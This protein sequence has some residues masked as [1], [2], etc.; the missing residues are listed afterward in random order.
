MRAVMVR[1]WPIL[2][3]CATAAMAACGGPNRPSPNVKEKVTTAEQPPPS[4]ITRSRE[5]A[6][7]FKPTS[8]PGDAPTIYVRDERSSRL[9]VKLPKGGKAKEEWTQPLGGTAKRL[10]CRGLCTPMQASFVLAAG[11]RVAVAGAEEWVTFDTN[12]R[13]V[14]RGKIEAPSGQ[15]RLDRAA[16]TIV[17]DETRAADLP[18][19]AKVAARNGL[20]VLV[21][22]GGVF[23]GEKAIEGKFDAFD[24]AIDEAGYACVLVRQADDLLMWTV[25]VDNK[26]SIGRQKLPG[27]AANARKRV[28]G[29]PVLGKNLR[30]V[31][32][33]THALAL[34]LEGKKI[35]ERKGVPTGGMSITA[36]DHVLIADNG[37]VLAIDPKGKTTELWSSKDAIF[38]TPPILNAS[39]MLFVASGESLH[40]VS[41]RE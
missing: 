12:G 5:E 8:G 25:P 41:I 19:D 6:E 10:P 4:T 27:G 26:G 32:L 24:V 36:D 18:A 35:W 37:K 33:D 2:L 15:V 16:G 21:K 7:A 38:V 20:V 13:G 17:P 23:V 30:V 31:Q 1:Y 9:D 34:S 39:G 22:N 14:D 29:P 3:G 40:A 28:L 11:N